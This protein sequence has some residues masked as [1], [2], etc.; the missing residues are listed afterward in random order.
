MF[1]SHDPREDSVKSFES[2]ENEVGVGVGQKGPGMRRDH[3][4][5]IF[6]L[7]SEAAASE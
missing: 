3:Q 6:Q 5:R 1:P 4:S 2:K 7:S